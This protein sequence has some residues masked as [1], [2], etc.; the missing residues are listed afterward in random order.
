[1]IKIIEPGTLNRVRC[2]YCNALLEYS[3]EDL[4]GTYTTLYGQKVRNNTYLIC[5]SCNSVIRFETKEKVDDD[6][7]YWSRI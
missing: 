2:H 7:Y 5:P 4:Q 3:K 1:M 6:W